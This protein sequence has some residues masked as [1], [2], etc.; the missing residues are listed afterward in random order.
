VLTSYIGNFFKRKRI[1]GKVRGCNLFN[2][3]W[4][5]SPLKHGKCATFFK[6]FTLNTYSHVLGD[7]C[8]RKRRSMGIKI[9]ILLGSQLPFPLLISYSSQIERERER[10]RERVWTSLLLAFD[11]INFAHAKK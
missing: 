6:L 7:L 8:R 5:V 2:C 3:L 4:R 10:E 1:G 9:F 11:M